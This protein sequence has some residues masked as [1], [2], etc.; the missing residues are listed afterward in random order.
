MKKIK[1][2]S[3]CTALVFLF[4]CQK[5]LK[6]EFQN[7]ETF[8]PTPEELI[9]GMFTSM[10]H[11][12]KFYIKDY[13]LWYWMLNGGTSV[14]GYSQI[15]Q[16]Y[17]TPRYDWF[18]DYDDLVTGNGMNSENDDG[19]LF[20]DFYIR[21]RNWAAMK[22][23]LATFSGQDLAD[24]EIFFQLA[25]VEK[26]WGALRNVDLFNS[27]PYFDA[28]KGAQGVF[29]P[30]Y[31]DPKIIYDSV[32]TELKNL[33]DQLPQTYSGMSAEAKEVLQSQDFA[34]H[35]DISKWIQYI[36]ALRLRFAVRISGVDE[37][38]AKETIQD[39]LSKNDFPQEDLI[40][41]VPE[42][43]NVLSGGM[44]ERGLYEN[45]Y[46]TFIPDVILKRMNFDLLT[47]QP[48]T[49]DPRLPVIAMPTKYGDYR[50]VSYNADAQDSAYKA[51]D[52][53]YPYADDIQASL[54][55]NAKSMYN[56]ATYTHN[57][58]PGIMFTRAEVD[59]LLAEVELKGLGSTGKSAGDH[60]HDAVVH[61]TDFWYQI[62][63]LQGDDKKEEWRQDPSVKTLFPSKPSDDIIASYADKVK[64][65][66]ESAGSLDDKMEI[67]M[68]QKYIHVNLMDPDE[69]FSELRRTR[70]PK[71]EP[72]TIN[73][74]VMKPMPERLKYPSSELG[75]NADNYLQ[76]RDQDNYTSFIFWI[77]PSLQNVSYYMNGY[78][79]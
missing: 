6:K 34:L 19:T 25:T 77:P 41:T 43:N 57:D 12:Y 30:K 55:Q 51:G 72:M 22:D 21:M 68:Q 7:P 38:F 26:D 54:E 75:T 65:A 59:L 15:A 58:F 16:R 31:D 79:N 2:I 39:L 42:K 74:K 73:G 35:G 17:I 53:Y 4:S 60:I 44:W 10:L 33:E 5:E 63:P 49:D 69:L 45:A 76:V 20:N 56:F 40:F 9:P 62:N 48:H 27:I 28:L 29:F 64:Q 71:L 78:I 67:L 61:S 50:A 24:N 46:A 52:T 14:T 18:V 1:Y 70:H 8:D 37:A 3:L 23:K 32:I 66:F 11:Q 36:H 47:Y 13:G